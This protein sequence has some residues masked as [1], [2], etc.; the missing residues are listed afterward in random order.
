MS[1]NTVFRGFEN[2]GDAG[3]SDILEQSIYGY[4]NWAF[5]GIGNWT[6]VERAASG[7]YGGDQSRLRLADDPNYEQGC[8]WEGFRRDWVWESGVDRAEQPIHVSGVWVD[9]SFYSIDATGTY[10][11]YVDY[12]N[13]RIVFEESI[14][15]SSVVQASYSYRHVHV[16]TADDYWW[17]ELQTYSNRNDDEQFLQSSSGVWSALA[18]N[19]IQLPAVIIEAAPEVDIRLLNMGTTNTVHRQTLNFF[20]LA[21]TRFDRNR[22]HDI[23]T[24]Q[25]AKRL[26]AL[27][28]DAMVAAT[29]YPLDEYGSPMPDARMYP[30]L[31]QPEVYGGFGSL[32][33][34]VEGVTSMPMPMQNY[35]GLYGSLVRWAC[36]VD[37]P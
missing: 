9:S 26:N 11:H 29:G 30:E 1:T 18:Q 22:I 19:R 25:Y 14:S 35:G 32:Q 23:L 3:L 21:E 24:R 27:D 37:L 8:V 33:I 15:A 16:T 28:I 31:V 13:G 34:R 10:A 2:Y 36:E 7:W 17:R 4:F 12:P 6:S 5:L 20:V